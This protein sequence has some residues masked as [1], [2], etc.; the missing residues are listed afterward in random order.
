VLYISGG[1]GLFACLECWR[2]VT[3]AASVAS[4]ALFA[5]YFNPWLSL[6]QVGA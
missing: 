6:A 2:T 3:A 4:L 1:V 5:L